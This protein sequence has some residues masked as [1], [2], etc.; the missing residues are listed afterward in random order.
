MV[1]LRL[2]ELREHKK[3]TQAEVSQYLNIARTT[4]ARYESEEREMTYDALVALAELFSVSVDYLLGGQEKNSMILHDHEI[5][6]IYKF[7]ALDE[8]GKCSVQAIIEHEYSV[9]T[10]HVKKPA[11]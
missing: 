1:S 5:T 6:M 3:L 11:I 7:R 4:Y 8:R 10:E 2:K 9:F